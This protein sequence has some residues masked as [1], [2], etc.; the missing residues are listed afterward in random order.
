[1]PSLAATPVTPQNKCPSARLKI[2]AEYACDADSSFGNIA[3]EFDWGFER[4]C[5][6]ACDLLTTVGFNYAEAKIDKYIEQG[7]IIA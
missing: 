5:L 4:F 7:A 6:E 1:M 3:E 2:I